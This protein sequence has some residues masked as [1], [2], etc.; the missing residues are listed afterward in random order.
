MFIDKQ[1]A[2]RNQ[3]RISEKTLFMVAIM[4]GSVGSLLG[5]TYFRHKTKHVKFVV[6][7][8]LIAIIQISAFIYIRSLVD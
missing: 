5:M 6:G 2:I 3:W 8:W 1:K 4:G 7:F